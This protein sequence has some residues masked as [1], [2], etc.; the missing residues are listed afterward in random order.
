M[1]NVREPVL[2]SLHGSQNELPAARPF[3]GWAIFASAIGLFSLLTIFS[4][5]LIPFSLIAVLLGTIVSLRLS[6]PDANY[7]LWI[8]NLGLGLGLAS[9]ISALAAHK[10]SSDHYTEVAKK[11]V[12]E[13]VELL[14]SG[15]VYNALELQFPF[16]QRQPEGTD[17]EGLYE[18]Y[19]GEIDLNVLPKKGNSDEE[20]PEEK[21][22]GRKR[23][24]ERFRKDS[25]T[26]FVLNHPNA[27]WVCSE[28]TVVESKGNYS[29]YKTVIES[30][31]IPNKRLKFELIRN[32]S[33][34]NETD[35][36]AEWRMG[37]Q[38]FGK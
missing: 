11:F 20:S 16:V 27:K 37:D 6:K 28:A 19:Q 13:Y 33:K 15:H 3:S 32:R 8:A 18:A 1:S 14:A 9:G 5:K 10:T 35:R 12:I 25:V 24:I 38:E 36:T 22:M 23:M 34:T 30:P 2:P 29:K 17:L 21:A 26:E 4:V 31:D 7:G